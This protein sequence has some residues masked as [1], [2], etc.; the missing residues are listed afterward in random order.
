MAIEIACVPG[1][2][3]ART[4]QWSASTGVTTI[5][6]A[7]LAE[8]I[9]AMECPAVRDP[10]I[11]LGHTDPR[12]DGQPAIGRVTNLEVVDEYSLRGDLDGMPGWLGEILASAYPARSIEA[13]WNHRCS[14]GH[15]HPFVLTGL[16]LLGVTAPAI[17]SLA[18]IAALWGVDTTTQAADVI[19]AGKGIVMPK[20]VAASATV[21]DIRRAYYDTASYDFWVEEIQLA[22]LQLIV[23][24]DIDGSRLRVP[25]A[26]DPERD[27]QDAITFGEAVPV[28]VRYDDVPPPPAPEQGDPSVAPVAVAASSLRFASRADSL[29]EVRAGNNSEGGDM[30]GSN[31]VA[32]AAP[33]SGDANPGGLTDDQLAKLREAV[34][35]TE[36][37]D[38]AVLA[39]ALEAVVTKVKADD[40]TDTGEEETEETAET[41]T[42]TGSSEEDDPEKKKVAVAASRNKVG[43]PTPAA[44]PAT[45]TV[46]A[47]QFSAMTETIGRFEQ[48][49]KEQ[50]E[51]RADE[52][53]DAA[54]KAGKIA[55]PSVA[56]YK[57]LARNDYAGTKQVLDS[58]AASAAFPVGEFGHSVDAEPTNDVREDSTYKNWSI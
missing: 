12:F 2:E 47:A 13:E 19:A 5:T 48:F 4:G 54:F 18:D 14:V 27:G 24:N 33:G 46:D 3:L 32:A 35:L 31:R 28:V 55:R 22:P 20:S 17:G 10:V 26:V 49:E 30:A 36:D 6:R 1:V 16:S 23:V 9:A 29:R 52:M 56:A 11:K 44:T 21:E 37:A 58:L 25:V 34:G 42:E 50:A 38:P 45:V 7:D 53:V 8:A 43:V 40:S 41:G 39:S 51:K 57:T 15:T